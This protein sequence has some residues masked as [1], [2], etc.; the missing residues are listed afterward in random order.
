MPS[1]VPRS[2]LS[3]LCS[4]PLC[5]LARAF[6]SAIMLICVSVCVCVV[7]FR[8]YYSRRFLPGPIHRFFLHTL[9]TPLIIFW[10]VWGTWLP[11]RLPLAMVF[12]KPITCNKI[13]HPS[14]RTIQTTQ[15]QKQLP[16]PTT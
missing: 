10:G 14:K 16:S 11:K 8:R 13:Q 4:V 2:H 12:G 1:L 9:R 15:T 6:G 5:Q 3:S 7:C